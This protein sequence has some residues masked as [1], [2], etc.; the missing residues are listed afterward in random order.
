[1]IMMMA[2]LLSVGVWV[3][4]PEP[5]FSTHLWSVGLSARFYPVEKWRPLSFDPKA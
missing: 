2:V 3:R 5:F 1:M 4:E